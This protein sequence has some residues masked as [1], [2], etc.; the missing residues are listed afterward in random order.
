MKFEVIIERHYPHS[1]ADVWDG[2]TTNEALSDWLME[3]SNFKAEVGTRFE[4]TCVD[5]DGH[6][7]V[8]RCKV[9]QLDPPNLMVWSWVLA[10]NEEKGHTEVEFRLTATDTGTQVQ[11]LHRGDRDKEMLERFKAGWPA[12]L[13]QLAEVLKHRQ[14]EAGRNS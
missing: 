1:I 3:T 6:L 7:D 10:G 2:L 12:K 11:L 4:M 5:D 14:G 9:L 8:Y 13:D